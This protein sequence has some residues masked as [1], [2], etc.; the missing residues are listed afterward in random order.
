[1]PAGSGYTVGNLKFKI[2][3]PAGN[4]NTVT[5]APQTPSPADP[6]GNGWT[7]VADTMLCLRYIQG[8]D[9]T[10]LVAKYPNIVSMCDVGP[11]I[12]DA[13]NKKMV[14]PNGVVD[15]YDAMAILRKAMGIDIWN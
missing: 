11:M 8:T 1:L 4:V 13:S 2:T 5:W 6:D 9:R 7:S 3:D 12:T 14:V 15:I 10:G